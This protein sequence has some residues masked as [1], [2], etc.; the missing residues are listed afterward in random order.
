M[1]ATD[2]AACLDQID[3]GD[4]GGGDD[5]ESSMAGDGSRHFTEHRINS[6]SSPAV[7]FPKAAKSVAEAPSKAPNNTC[8]NFL[9]FPNQLLTLV[10]ASHVALDYRT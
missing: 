10:E 6:Y 2:T 1:T 8:S 7:T 9:P 4:G 3:S 5:D